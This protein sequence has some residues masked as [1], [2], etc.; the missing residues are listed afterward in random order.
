MLGVTSERVNGG[1]GQAWRPRLAPRPGIRIVMALERLMRCPERGNEATHKNGR[2]HTG[3]A[4]RLSGY[5]RARYSYRSASIGLSAAALRAGQN[6]KNTPT[7]AEKPSATL[8]VTP[9]MT[10]G[11]PVSRPTSQLPP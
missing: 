9:S 4:V 10:V 1:A 8:T 6:P 2:P 3:A 5:R 11:Q 7:A